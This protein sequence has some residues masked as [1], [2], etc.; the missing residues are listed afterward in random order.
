LVE[1]PE[2]TTNL[3]EITDKLSHTVLYG[4]YMYLAMSRISL[5]NIRNSEHYE[6]ESLN[7]DCQQY[8]TLIISTY[9]VH[10]PR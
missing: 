5:V 2:K 3:S 8:H 4:I 10:D 9:V 1:Y 7:S 6:K